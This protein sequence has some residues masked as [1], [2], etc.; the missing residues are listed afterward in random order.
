MSNNYFTRPSSPPVDPGTELDMISTELHDH[1]V[2]P[3]ED[4]DVSYRRM[5]LSESLNLW[6]NMCWLREWQVKH[7]AL[8]DDVTTNHSERKRTIGR[9]TWMGRNAEA[10]STLYAEREKTG[11][12][13]AHMQDFGESIEQRLVRGMRFRGNAPPGT[14]KDIGVVLEKVR[15]ARAARALSS[16]CRI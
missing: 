1:A 16:T 3:S 2:K 13:N 5:T 12:V 15:L 4:E 8:F 6:N 7:R 14:G 9:L 10:L 11:K